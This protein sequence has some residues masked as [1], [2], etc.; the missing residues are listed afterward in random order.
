MHN[1]FGQI[2]M[3][4]VTETFKSEKQETEGLLCDTFP[5]KLHR[6]LEKR[7]QIQDLGEPLLFYLLDWL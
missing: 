3:P 6:Q 5:S 4:A 1:L 7:E 2:H